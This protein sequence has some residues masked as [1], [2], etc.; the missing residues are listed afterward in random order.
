MTEDPKQTAIDEINRLMAQ[1]HNPRDCEYLL[2]E[3]RR[4]HKWASAPPRPKDEKG[5]EFSDHLRAHARD[6]ATQAALCGH[7][8]AEQLVSIEDFEKLA[9][10]WK[11]ES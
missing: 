2:D 6:E 11:C 8:G 1:W 10:K 4:M 7:K 9:G 3:A 5:R